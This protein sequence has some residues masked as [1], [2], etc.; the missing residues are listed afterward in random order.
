MPL[1][2]SASVGFRGGSAVTP[3][4]VPWLGGFVD[5]TPD[6][7]LDAA[8]LF[9][10]E[11]IHG[12]ISVET[13]MARF[14]SEPNMC[15]MFG[16]KAHDIMGVF[17]VE[18]ALAAEIEVSD[19]LTATPHTTA[20]VEAYL[21]TGADLSMLESLRLESPLQTISGRVTLVST[22]DVDP[23]TA[24]RRVTLR[25]TPTLDAYVGNC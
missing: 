14:N 5:L 9:A 4:V 20:L 22:I 16:A 24:G 25:S 8:K 15:A 6:Q 2:V 1:V 23:V 3:T 10:D 18:V 17:L 11:V 7:Q 21:A 13:I 19:L 12:R